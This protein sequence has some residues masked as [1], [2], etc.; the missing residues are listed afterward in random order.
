VQGARRATRPFTAAVGRAVAATGLTPNMVT[1]LQLVLAVPVAWALWKGPLPWAAL[2]FGVVASLDW[3]DGA[4]ARAS[5]KA[6]LAGGYLDSLVDR[7]VDAIVL[8]GLLL[9]YDTTKVWLAGSAYLVA[10]TV[11]SFARARLFQD[12]RP[13]PPETWS[14]DVLER[15]ERCVLFGLAV[16]AQGL[17]DA[18]GRHVEVVFWSLC[19]LALLALVTVLQRM[20]TSLRLLR[21]A[22]RGA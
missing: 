17:V 7:F 21:E 5:G 16:L 20:A 2:L 18:F 8:L 19:V 22:D 10:M 11:T 6:S 12:L 4:V 13:P 3:V 15:T 1:L 9:R 14:R